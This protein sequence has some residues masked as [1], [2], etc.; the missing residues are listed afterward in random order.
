MPR[1]LLLSLCLAL[2]FTIAVHTSNA[3]QLDE[4]DDEIIVR[5]PEPPNHLSTEIPKDEQERAVIFRGL[6]ETVDSIYF[7][8]EHEGVSRKEKE[9]LVLA[10]LL[11]TVKMDP[12]L[13][14]QRPLQ[15]NWMEDLH[16][17]TLALAPSDA[18]WKVYQRQP[19][20]EQFDS[21][22]N[23]DK[24]AQERSKD[25]DDLR[26]YAFTPH[27]DRGMVSSLSVSFSSMILQT[28]QHF[29]GYSTP[30]NDAMTALASKY[31][32]IVEVGAGN[33]YWSAALQL[34]GADVATYDSEP[35]RNLEDDHNPNL[36]SHVGTPFVSVEQGTCVEVLKAHPEYSERSLMMIW[37]NNPDHLDNPDQFHEGADKLPIWDVE[38]L[39][40]YLEMG[41]S[42]VIYVGEREEQILVRL[43]YFPPDIGMS[44]SKKFQS[45]LKEQF[46]RVERFELPTWWGVDDLT[47]WKR[48][49]NS[50]NQ[51]QEQEL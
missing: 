32:P 31:S 29:G 1:L 42:T 7:G 41:G 50:E 39:E 5:I 21:I 8:E 27:R 35:P 17:K 28:L 18:F 9:H 16:R 15:E 14:D 24:Y 25:L 26:R 19:N 2:L 3:Q 51:E 49:T 20:Q 45:M 23:L 34:N 11:R 46:D 10:E 13:M 30:T 47:V 48:K 6:M 37:P 22:V 40:A 44:S 36:F 4:E 12:L 33:G 43:E 38:C